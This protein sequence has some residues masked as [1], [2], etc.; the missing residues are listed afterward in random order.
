[1]AIFWPPS[2][3]EERRKK[4]GLSLVL[5]MQINCQGPENAGAVA[6][7]GES[8]KRNTGTGKRLRYPESQGLEVLGK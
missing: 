4:E 3:G 6:V 5:D 7:W 8:L 2:L 1:M